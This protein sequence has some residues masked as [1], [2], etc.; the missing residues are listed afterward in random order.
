MVFLTDFY[1]SCEKEKGQ[2]L[3]IVVL[4]IVVTLTVGLSLASRSIVQLRNTTDEANSQ[5]AFSAAEAGVEQ[6]IKLGDVSGSGVI[7]GI[8]L[9][10]KNNSQIGSVDVTLIK[11]DSVLLNNGLPLFQDNGADLWLSPYDTDQSNLFDS[12]KAFN[13][14]LTVYW[15]TNSDPCADP[16]MEILIISGTRTS[17]TLSKYAFDQ[18]GSNSTQANKRNN[19]FPD[20]PQKVTPST[21]SQFTISGTNGDITFNYKAQIAVSSGLI[22]RV[23]PLYHGGSVGAS[24]IGLPEQGKIITSTGTAGLSGQQVVR[25]VSFFQGFEQLPIQFYYS[26][27]TAK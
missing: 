9:N 27:F 8:N 4:V 2:A 5:A 3:L 14:T 13:G 26:L 6:A 24:G 16:A 7:S 10:D 22:A 23:I 18:C 12:A 20:A 15:G 21:E 11:S 25:K 19:G 1:R 17:P